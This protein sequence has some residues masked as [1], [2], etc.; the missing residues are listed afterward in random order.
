MLILGRT[1]TN[2]NYKPSH[3]KC[4][5]Y[6]LINSHFII[7]IKLKYLNFM[8]Y[9]ILMNNFF[10]VETQC[11]KSWHCSLWLG[12][13]RNSTTSNF[14]YNSGKPILYPKWDFFEPDN[15]N[16]NENCVA[17]FRLQ[18]MHDF[19][20]DYNNFQYICKMKNWCE[21]KLDICRLAQFGLCFSKVYFISNIFV[22]NQFVV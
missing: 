11:S 19:D 22:S 16:G 1:P 18:K 17:L 5:L 14:S 20:C 3:L 8:M 7:R 4:N 10:P 13:S 12:S 6:Q 9:D 2:S 15:R 21:I